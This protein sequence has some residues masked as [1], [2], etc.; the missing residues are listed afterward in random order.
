MSLV[1][2]GTIRKTQ[3][4]AI[5]HDRTQIL[6]LASA[7]RRQRLRPSQE[8]AARKNTLQADKSAEVDGEVQKLLRESVDKIEAM[9]A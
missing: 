9:E 6:L 4:S 3:H 2:S 1:P 8:G 5:A 7:R